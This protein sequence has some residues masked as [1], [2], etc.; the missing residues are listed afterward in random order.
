MND[1]VI[2]GAHTLVARSLAQRLADRAIGNVVLATTSEFIEP[3]LDLIDEGLLRRSGLWVLAMAGDLP[4]RIADAMAARGQP[5]LDVAGV[6]DDGPMLWPYLE[7]GVSVASGLQAGLHRLAVGPAGPIGAVLRALSVF[8]PQVVRATTFES[9]AARGQPGLDELSEQTRAVFS[10]REVDVD[11]F[12]ASLAFDAIPSLA[13]GDDPPEDA[14]QA[15]VD[16]VLAGLHAAGQPPVDLVATRVLVPSFVAEAAVLHIT[17]ED[18]TPERTTV[19]DALRRGRGLRYVE[20]VV[21]PSLDAVDR[22]DMLVSRVRTGRRH[23][24]LWLTYDLSRAG[25]AVPAALLIDG[26]CQRWS[27]VDPSRE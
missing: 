5:V 11:V 25:S 7:A 21:V 3:D 13:T 23:I 1:I 27:G 14:D 17:T 16:Q 6:F 19:I 10:L 8:R 18:S 24:D 2:L 9:A 12:P 22:D 4:R 15:L 26:W 20:T